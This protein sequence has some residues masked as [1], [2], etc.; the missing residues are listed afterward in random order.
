MPGGGGTSS[1]GCACA[2]ASCRYTA[3]SGPYLN[4]R[5]SPNP[6]VPGQPVQTPPCPQ[7]AGSMLDGS[8]TERLPTAATCMNLLKLPPY[9]T[10]EA[11]RQKLLYAMAEGAGFELS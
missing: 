7:M 11:V 9:R 6:P 2:D 1:R 8:C 5:I 4:R 3:T 10:A